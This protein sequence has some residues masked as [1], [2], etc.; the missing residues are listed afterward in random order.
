MGLKGC[1]A[2]DE[3]CRSERDLTRSFDEVGKEWPK[4]E[5]WGLGFRLQI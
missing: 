1:R 2:E 5:E 4:K 3:N